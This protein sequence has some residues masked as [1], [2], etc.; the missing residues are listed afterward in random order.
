[1]IGSGG[2]NVDVEVDVSANFNTIPFAINDVQVSAYLSTDC[3]LDSA[4]QFL[5][6]AQVDFAIGESV[7]TQSLNFDM[8]LDVSNNSRI[9]WVVD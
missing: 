4:D 6:S 7:I 5:G 8:P 2:D 9:I 1:L 3:E